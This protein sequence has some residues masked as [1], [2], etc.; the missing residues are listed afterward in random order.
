MPT[1]R[2]SMDSAAPRYVHVVKSVVEYATTVWLFV[3]T[4]GSPDCWKQQLAQPADVAQQST[5]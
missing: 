3:Y 4:Q 5:P 2:A 1:R